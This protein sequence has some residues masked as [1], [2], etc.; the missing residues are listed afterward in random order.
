MAQNYLRVYESMLEGTVRSA[1]AEP[2]RA[3]PV[4]VQAATEASAEVA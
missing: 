4:G 3:L 1:A 2:A